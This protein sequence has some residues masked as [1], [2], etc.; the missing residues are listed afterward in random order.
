MS[1]YGET[2]ETKELVEGS[3]FIFKRVISVACCEKSDIGE[4]TYNYLL[5]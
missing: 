3:T 5:I 1:I 2:S 4:F